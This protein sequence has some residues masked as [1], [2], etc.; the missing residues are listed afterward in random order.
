MLGSGAMGVFVSH[1]QRTPTVHPRASRS[2]AAMGGGRTAKRV[3]EV[4]EGATPSR[5]EI[6][7]TFETC[8]SVQ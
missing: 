7:S 2:L 1:G 3:G 5:S 6:V 4:T 8:D